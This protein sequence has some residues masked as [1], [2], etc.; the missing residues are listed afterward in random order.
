MVMKRVELRDGGMFSNVNEVVQRLH[1]AQLG[2][3]E[4]AIRWPRS[5]YRDDDRPDDPWSYFF[6]PCFAEDD[7]DVAAL[8]HWDEF[9]TVIRGADN[10]I[11][12]RASWR[13]G[14]ML[15]FPTNRHIAAQ[16]IKTRLKLK[17]NIQSIIDQY[18]DS[19]IGA[20]VMVNNRMHLLALATLVLLCLPSK[21]KAAEKPLIIGVADFPPYVI[22]QGYQFDDMTRGNGLDLDII[23]E[24]LKRTG[25]AYEVLFLPYAR[26]GYSL[27]NDIVNIQLSMFKDSKLPTCRYVQYD[28]GGTV[29]FYSRADNNFV[30]DSEDDL[31]NLS[32]GIVRDEYY[33]RYFDEVV[34]QQKVNQAY[35]TSYQQG[36]DM[37]MRERLEL[38]VINSVVGKHLI[39][40]LDITDQ[41][42]E[43]PLRLYYREDKQ[44]TS[45]NFLFS[46]AV[47][48]TVIEDIRRSVNQMRDEGFIE[49]L[50]QK[51]DILD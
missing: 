38:V 16:H 43:H 46:N 34:E 30:I 45:I 50:K 26:I 12:P 37:L 6:E 23:K 44:H 24:A 4:F 17:P 35:I 33:G 32:V 41:V 31:K 42:T 21:G 51:Y 36:F 1:L 11:T 28:T 27:D 29:S 3:F 8:E 9:G 10:T 15:I 20:E 14:G 48:Q 39:K 47:A 18:V 22:E 13:D 7:I 25:L 2:G 5:V 19:G 40:T 49:K